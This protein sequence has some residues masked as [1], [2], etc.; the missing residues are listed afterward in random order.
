M[1]EWVVA[2]VEAITVSKSREACQR[3]KY[4]P[5]IRNDILMPNEYPMGGGGEGARKGLSGALIPAFG[6][7]AAASIKAILKSRPGRNETLTMIRR[8]YGVFISP[9]E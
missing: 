6:P 9:G 1:G 4:L 8:A 5:S 3:K 7:W 2:W